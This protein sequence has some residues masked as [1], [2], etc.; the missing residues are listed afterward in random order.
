MNQF[1]KLLIG[2]TDQTWINLPEWVSCEMHPEEVIYRPPAR[3]LLSF[4]L[5]AFGKRHKV[6]LRVFFAN[7]FIAEYAI[8][9]LRHDLVGFCWYWGCRPKPVE[10]VGPL[11]AS[12]TVNS[13]GRQVPL[14]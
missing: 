11:V 4:R 14:T 3:R 7:N 2:D 13:R 5:K 9:K 12:C 8:P 10:N 1:S 6:F